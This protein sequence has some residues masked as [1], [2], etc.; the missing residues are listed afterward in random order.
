MTRVLPLPAPVRIRTGPSAVSTASRCWGLRSLRN[1]KVLTTLF[2]ADCQWPIFEWKTGRA[3]ISQAL[4][5][6]LSFLA[7]RGISVFPFSNWQLPID[8]SY[9][10][11]SL[12]RFPHRLAF[13]TG[14]HIPQELPGVEP[15]VV[16][17]IPAKFDGIAAHR[18]DLVRLGRRLKHRQRTG[19]KLGRVSRLT[20]GLATFFIA[21][22][23]RTGI[24]KE[25]KAVVRNM[26]V[27]PLDFHTGAGGNVHLHR[28][29]FCPRLPV[30]SI[31][32]RARDEPMR[33]SA[34]V[35]RNRCPSGKINS[36]QI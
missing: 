20:A 12:Y 17:V 25:G 30:F 18:F 31:A 2:I 24:S 21:Q 6:V 29:G 5:E 1:D 33:I 34:L 23:A 11:L 10:A 4:P 15:E 28:L 3:C 36:L 26:P 35:C 16:I 14:A 22:G 8:N 9:S 7:Q 19:R 13:C 27:L 32:Q